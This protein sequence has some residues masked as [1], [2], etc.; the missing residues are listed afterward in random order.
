MPTAQGDMEGRNASYHGSSSGFVQ[1]Q[2]SLMPQPALG[3]QRVIYGNGTS[4]GTVIALHC[5]DKHKLMGDSV[6]CVLEGN[7]TMW[8]GET[9][10]RPLSYNELHGLQLALLISVVSF[11]VI[12]FMS[13]A[14]LTCCLVNCIEKRKR[15]EMERDSEMPLQWEEQRHQQEMNRRCNN[16]GR[17]NNNNNF[18]E[19]EWIQK[20]HHGG[21]ECRCPHQGSYDPSSSYEVTS[22]FPVLPGYQYDQPLLPPD[23]CS[24]NLH[25]Q[26]LEYSRQ[27]LC[28]DMVLV[29]SSSFDPVWQPARKQNS[30][31]RVISV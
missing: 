3:F 30:N 28:S 22:R 1:T 2:C 19:Q 12:C 23:P 5:P 17:N 15:K 20:N 24:S 6:K 21:S 8:Q 14:F 4:V 9:Y 25:R 7:S 11:A 31:I 16:K 27:S 18:M 29:D 13:T 26:T 10:C